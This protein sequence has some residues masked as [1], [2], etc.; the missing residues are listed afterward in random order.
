MTEISYN[1]WIG[2]L[3]SRQ[4]ITTLPVNLKDN[5]EYDEDEYFS[6]QKKVYEREIQFAN[7]VGVITE[8]Q[9]SLKPLEI[10]FMQSSAL[11]DEQKFKEIRK[12]MV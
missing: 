5:Q 10:G 8:Q 3:A 1:L 7:R 11:K 6:E 12:I 4:P 2:W 9:F